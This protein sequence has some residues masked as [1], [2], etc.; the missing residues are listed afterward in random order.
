MTTCKIC[1]FDLDWNECIRCDYYRKAEE[2]RMHWEARGI[3]KQ[4]KERW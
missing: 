2:E 1:G 4:E 3:F